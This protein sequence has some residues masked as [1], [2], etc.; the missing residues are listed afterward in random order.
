MDPQHSRCIRNAGMVQNE[1]QTR[2]DSSGKLYPRVLSFV[3]GSRI[4][5]VTFLVG[6]CVVSAIFESGV[7]VGV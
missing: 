5:V 6:D 2:R 4:E 1:D 3:L 7:G